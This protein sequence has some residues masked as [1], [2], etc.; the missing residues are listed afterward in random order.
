M[1][2]YLCLDCGKDFFC[3]C[4]SRCTHA[5]PYCHSLNLKGVDTLI[6]LKKENKLEGILQ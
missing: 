3:G 6:Q 2:R 4:P 1:T 5:C